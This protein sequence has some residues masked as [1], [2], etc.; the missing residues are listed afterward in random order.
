MKI[1]GREE[2]QKKLQEAV[3]SSEAEMIAVIGRR[4][5]GKTFLVN[6]VYADR[7]S[8]ELTG[9]QNA[10]LRQQLK[11]FA[12]RMSEATGEKKDPPADWFDAFVQLIDYLKT[13]TGKEKTVVFLDELPWLAT[14][15]S[16]FL[17][18]L[19]FFWNSWAV[20]Q[21]IVVVICGSAASWMIQKVVNH[22]GG[23]HNRIT[24]ILHLK[25]FSLRET[26]IYLQHR[27]INLDRYQI[28][29]I[30]FATGG[31]PHYLKEIKNGKSAVQNINDICFA[32]TGLL[33]KEFTRLYHSL[34]QNAERHIKIIRALADIQKGAERKEIAR[35]VDMTDGGGFKRT[36]EELEYSGFIASYYPFGKKRKGVLYRLTDE[37]SLFYLKFIENKKSLETDVWQKLSQSQTY[38]TWTGYAYENLCLKHI[39]QIK[40]AMS[41][42]G[43]YSEAS[44]FYHKGNDELPGLQID[45]LI[46][47]SD[48]I[49]NLFE[50]KF[51][52]NPDML[53]K[54]F[55]E[56]L[57]KKE[58]IF[59]ELTGT[60]KQIFSVLITTFPP[61]E[62]AN[63]NAISSILTLDDL[64]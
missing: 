7:L 46:D 10:D 33:N 8:F 38:K 63:S 56:N 16:G 6:T 55:I 9:I 2:E 26:E 40:K 35:R 64:F 22:R 15:R 32:P 53:R 42:A 62:N 37:Y 5:V 20:K 52:N 44:S 29:Q 49:F 3:Q 27:N 23:L 47:R 48:R 4:R 17:Q 39:P 1:I 12:Y 41:I 51:E 58:S 18:G 19:S 34:F 60:K 61:I 43:I 21:N 36:L 30:Y 50:F 57:R 14:P 45:L 24:K 13:R 31:V 54:D 25:P 28:A 59:K 11:N